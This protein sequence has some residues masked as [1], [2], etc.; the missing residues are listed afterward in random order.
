MK[1]LLNLNSL[2]WV[3]HHLHIDKSNTI[4][5]ARLDKSLV[6]MR[7]KWILMRDIKTKYTSHDLKKRMLKTTSMI[8]K[9]GCR[10][11][12]TFIDID[13]IVGLEPLYTAID[14]KNYW[15]PR[16]IELQLGTQLLEGLETPENIKLFDEAAELVDFIGCLP[17]RDTSP[18]KHLDIV[19]SKASDMGKDIEAHLDQC[20]IPSEKETELFCDFVEKYKYQGKSRAI[21]CV[22]LAC[23]PLDYQRKISK[24]L[25]NLDIGVIVCPSAAI[26]MTQ[27]NEYN[28]PIHNSIAP[29]KVMLDEKVNVGLGIDN[30]E[31][32]FMPFCD[33]DLMF[34]LRLLAETERIYKPDILIDIANNEMGFK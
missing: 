3:C 32:I 29:I 31:D 30:V 21:H 10:K 14:V 34:E 8:M 18:E 11:M 15:K 28:A 27:H 22:S 7:N 26:S 16:G 12:R 2:K 1:N 23:H 24:R 33:G 17:S 13:N 19:F 25:H 4:T 5:N 9:Q 20:N 6:H